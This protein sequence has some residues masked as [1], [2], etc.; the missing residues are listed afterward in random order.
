M[1]T[2]GRLLDKNNAKCSFYVNSKSLLSS[3]NVIPQIPQMK[4]LI[5]GITSS[6]N[7]MAMSADKY[8]Q[9][10]YDIW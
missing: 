2:A 9:S 7:V 10:A 6:N 8:K 3:Y 4:Y 5:Y 1:S